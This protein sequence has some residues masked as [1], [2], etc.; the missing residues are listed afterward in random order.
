[1]ETEQN[2]GKRVLKLVHLNVKILTS[3]YEVVEYG[4]DLLKRRLCFARRN[5]ESLF[6]SEDDCHLTL[7]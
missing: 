4:L 7:N 6:F 2:K 1:M 3:S 5:P